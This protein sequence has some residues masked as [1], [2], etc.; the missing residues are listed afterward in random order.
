MRVGI[1]ATLAAAGGL[2]VAG[3]L[4]VATAEAPTS[5]SPPRTVSV[6]GVASEA[7]DQSA[8]TSTAQG[9]YRQGMADA[10]A[11]GL[12]KA[13]FLAS[14]VG[15]PL[16][17]VQSVVEQGGYIS[18]PG[19]AEYLGAQ[20]DFGTASGPVSAGAP[21]RAGARLRRPS[22]ARAKRRKHRAT[23]IAKAGGVTCTL[24]TQVSLAYL[25]G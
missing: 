7:I 19:E 14:K 13:Q 24:Y 4:G 5:P 17:A 8:A 10:I 18:C 21:V 12:G 9:V 6:Q 2:L 25:L 11:D 3:T 20:P 15:A 1:T 23:P 22:H 16:G